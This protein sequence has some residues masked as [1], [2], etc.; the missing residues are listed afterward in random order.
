MSSCGRVSSSARASRCVCTARSGT[1]R[2]TA[3]GKGYVLLHVSWKDQREQSC[4]QTDSCSGHFFVS[5]WCWFCSLWLALLS[6]KVV[7]NLMKSLWTMQFFCSLH[8]STGAS[9]AW[10]DRLCFIATKNGSKTV[11]CQVFLETLLLLA[12]SVTEQAFVW[13]QISKTRQKVT[14]V[15]H[16]TAEYEDSSSE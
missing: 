16:F 1:P 3:H 9:Q 6:F 11:F 13:K 12:T 15:T 4:D 7:H 8:V 14:F 10:Q 2:Y 5:W